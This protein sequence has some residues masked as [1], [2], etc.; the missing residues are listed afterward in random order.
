MLA[1]HKFSIQHVPGN[2]LAKV[3]LIYFLQYL[4]NT[5]YFKF[6]KLVFSRYVTTAIEQ[7]SSKITLWIWK[8]YERKNFVACHA[9]SLC[10][11]SELQYVHNATFTNRNILVSPLIY[12]VKMFC[13]FQFKIP[14]KTALALF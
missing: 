2:L 11:N 13:G 7:R 12:L 14:L 10:Y 8:L 4:I 1:S 9:L 3:I 5:Y 6:Y